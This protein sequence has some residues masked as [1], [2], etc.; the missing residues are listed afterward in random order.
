MIIVLLLF[1][2][3]RFLNRRWSNRTYSIGTFYDLVEFPT[4]QPYTP[5]LRTV[6]DLDAL[7]VRH[8]KCFITIRTLHN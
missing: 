1:L 2:A 5:A 3:I 8:D 4:I 6:V 7:A